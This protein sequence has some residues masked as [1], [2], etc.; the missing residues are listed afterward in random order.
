VLG[1]RF[2]P[3]EIKAGLEDQIIT[4]VP[5]LTRLP[6]RLN[7]GAENLQEGRTT[8]NVRMQADERDR[9]FITN[10]IQQLTVTLVA[11]PLAICGVILVVNVTG[12]MMLP[13]L[14]LY[15]FLGATLFFFAFVLAARALA[16]V[17]RHPARAGRPASADTHGRRRPARP[18]ARRTR[19]CGFSRGAA[20]R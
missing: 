15:T 19:W 14:R 9:R 2:S 12:P 6:R 5:L 10:L 3:S 18:P 1:N 16:L 7:A 11:G 20:G 13:A 17:F 8:V 4:L